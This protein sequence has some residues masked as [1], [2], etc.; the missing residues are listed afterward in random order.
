MLPAHHF[1]HSNRALKT[2]GAAL[3]PFNNNQLKDVP[4]VAERLIEAPWSGLDVCLCLLLLFS[5]LFRT[6]WW[7]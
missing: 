1:H 2:F 3:F 5:L 7:H 4:V 6:R